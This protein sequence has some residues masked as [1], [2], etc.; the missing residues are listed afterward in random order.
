MPT[1]GTHPRSPRA[2]SLFLCCAA[3]VVF[4][5][6]P[7][8]AGE[9]SQSSPAVVQDLTG[10]VGN[11]PDATW[12]LNGPV[13][14]MIQ[15]G[16]TLIV[17]GQFTELR[18]KPVGVEGGQVVPVSNLAAIDM[19]S[20]AAAAVQPPQVTGTGSIVYALAMAN[21]KLYFGGKFS[22]VDTQVRQNLAAIDVAT[23][24][25]DPFYPKLGVVWGLTAS[26][27]KLYAGGAFKAVN[28]KTRLKLAAWTL[29]DH[30]LDANFTPAADDR[31]RSLVLS[32]DGATLY[33]T[34]HFRNIGTEPRKTLAQ[35]TSDTGTVTSWTPDPTKIGDNAFGIDLRLEAG[36][37][38]VGEGGSDFVAA[39]DPLTAVQNWK[40]D[41]NGSAQAVS[42]LA[43]EVVVGG[44]FKF[45]AH[46]P[47][48]D[49]GTFGNSCASRLRLGALDLNGL[50]DNDWAP[51]VTGFYDG[52]WDLL[53]GT[54]DVPTQLWI[55]GEF[56]KVA[57]VKQSYLAR[58]SLP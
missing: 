24:A 7:A 46:G 35:L 55:G 3:M 52:T 15:S 51:S 41:T 49:C 54:T 32:E 1:F 19:V 29:P 14:A 37:L 47:G 48:E 26:G 27:T 56:T 12:N 8:G 40:T 11:T 22:A 58:F 25:L 57:G 9:N 10:V 13:R 50:L 30:T 23:Y 5:A 34:G 20:G 44:H 53:V 42:I 2:P 18:E 39:Y 16:T 6:V 43:G 28:G 4:L 17:G 21:G 36:V 38:Y 31:V 45:M 33:I